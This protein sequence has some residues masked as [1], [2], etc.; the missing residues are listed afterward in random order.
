VRP[1]SQKGYGS[2]E[3]F[4]Q[5]YTNVADDPWGLSWRPSQALRY[6]KVL[7]L[8][9]TIPQSFP[10]VIDIGCA[11]GDFTHLLS[12]RMPD[13]KVLLGVDFVEIA[14]EKAH[15]RFPNINFVKQSIFSL[16]ETYRSQFDLVSCLEVLYYLE[17]DQHSRALKSV[18]RVL[19]DR[20]Y[21]V[22][23]SFISE[24]PYFT[25]EQLL[26]LVSSE[27]QV[28]ASQVLHLKMVSLLEMVARRSD[29]LAV[30]L[31][32]G[33]WNGFGARTLCR[34]PFSTVSA[35]EK[36]SQSFKKSSASHTIVL[37]RAKC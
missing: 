20:G 9:E 1:Q 24:P 10:S 13:L 35:F 19:R 26:D 3:W 27:F 7:S 36:L 23:S 14:V 8:L 29:K 22:F 12:K 28:V 6:Q 18:R 33:K 30:K 37:A 34:L 31:S 17:K 16:G 5:E 15:Q 32:G 2:L 4:V 11:T 25:P 21:A